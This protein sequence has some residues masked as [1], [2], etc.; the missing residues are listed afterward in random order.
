MFLSPWRFRGGHLD[1]TT[2][3]TPHITFPTV[4]FTAKDLK[5]LKGI[6]KIV[7]RVNF[8]PK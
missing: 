4:M 8:G 7:K 2:A 1:Y 3:H 5:V 6:V